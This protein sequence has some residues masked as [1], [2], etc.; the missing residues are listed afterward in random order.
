MRPLKLS[1]TKSKENN[2]TV[3]IMGLG[4]RNEVC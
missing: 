2:F 4:N 1:P 3:E